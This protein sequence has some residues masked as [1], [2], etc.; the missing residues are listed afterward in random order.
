[1]GFVLHGWLET[2]VGPTI[3]ELR[4][5]YKTVIS[6]VDMCFVTNLLRL[7]EGLLTKKVL[8]TDL[9]E[10]LDTFFVWSAVWAFGSPLCMKDNV[11]YKKEFS[12]WWKSEHKAV[13]FPSRG[14][15]FDYFVD[16][17]TRKLEP[18]SK[19]V[20]VVE[21][22][23]GS[24]MNLITVPTPETVAVEFIMDMFFARG[25]APMLVGD[26][27][28]GK[29]Q[30]VIG[31]LRRMVD[32]G[33]GEWMFMP[34]NFNYYTDS[35]LLQSIMEQPLEKKAGINFGPPGKAKLVYMVDDLNMPKV[36]DYGTQNAISLLRQLVE[37]G[38]TYERNKFTLKNINKAQFV[39]CMTPRP[40]TPR[41]T[42][43]CSATS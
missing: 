33:E 8:T 40:A 5:A 13:K 37:Y 32:E 15:V 17:E 41:S 9:V 14:S 26:S 31:K 30:Q 39:A 25:W 38:H 28:T 34:I 4:R 16:V 24:A 43:A 35:G 21:F 19:I 20:P 11:D 2:Y 7:L 3:F 42:R 27:G 18:W 1:M 12:N 6:M 22:A 29:T 23:A 10:L 36:D